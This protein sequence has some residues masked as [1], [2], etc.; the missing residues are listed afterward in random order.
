MAA[1]P[2]RGAARAWVALSERSASTLG[3]VTQGGGAGR[4][5]A[6]PESKAA[7]I[8]AVRTVPRIGGTSTEATVSSAKPCDALIDINRRGPSARERLAGLHVCQ[9]RLQGP[10]VLS[11][12]RDEQGHPRMVDHQAIADS[13]SQLVGRKPSVEGLERRR[14]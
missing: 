13:L 8:A 2:G 11:G 6:T 3:G 10:F 1:D 14:V 4:H 5:P 9:E 12:E 7:V